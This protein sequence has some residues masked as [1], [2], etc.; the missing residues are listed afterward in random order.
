MP[1]LHISFLVNKRSLAKE[2]KMDNANIGREE[3]EKEIYGPRTRSDIGSSLLLPENPVSLQRATGGDPSNYFAP[4]PD[5]C[6]DEGSPDEMEKEDVD[7]GKDER[8]REIYGDSMRDDV[9]PP[10]HRSGNSVAL[11]HAISEGQFN[12]HATTMDLLPSSPVNE[13]LLNKEEMEDV[14]VGKEEKEK[15]IYGRMMRDDVDSP[16]HR[17]GNLVSLIHASSA[18]QHQTGT[19]FGVDENLLVPLVTARYEN[20]KTVITLHIGAQPNNS[21]HA[22]TMTVFTSAFAFAR[23]LL[24][25][26]QTRFKDMKPS[27]GQSAHDL[28]VN[29]QLDLVDTCPDDNANL[30]EDAYRCQRSHRFTESYITNK[31][32]LDY[33]GLLKTLSGRY[34]VSYIIKYQK[35]LL[36]LPGTPSII[37]NILNNRDRIST[38]ISPQKISLGLRCACPV[39]D[40]GLS[41]KH[42]VRNEYN[43]AQDHTTITFCCPIHGPHTIT[44]EKPDEI[45]RLEMNTPLRNLVRTLA[46]SEISAT[47]TSQETREF[48][49]RVTGADY[50]GFYQEQLSWRQLLLLSQFPQPPIFLYAP[51]IVDWAGSK[52]SKSLY[53]KKG[54]YTYMKDTNTDFLLSY[55]EA[56]EQK[57]DLSVLF[58]EVDNWLV[59][60]NEWIRTRSVE[61]MRM[62]FEDISRERGPFE[63]FHDDQVPDPLGS[64]SYAFEK[65]LACEIPHSIFLP[66]LYNKL[67]TIPRQFAMFI[68]NLSHSFGLQI[69]DSTSRL[70]TTLILHLDAR[71]DSSPTAANT[72]C[73]AVAFCLGQIL[74]QKHNDRSTHRDA[75]QLEAIVE[76]TLTG[77]DSS[78][79]HEYEEIAQK[80]QRFFDEQV[81]FVFKDETDF[82]RGEFLQ[83]CLRRV[84]ED[85]GSISPLLA[86]RNEALGIECTCRSSSPTIL[87]SDTF[88]C[89][90]HEIDLSSADNRSKLKLP[91]NLRNLL[92][93]LVYAKETV[94][95][96]Q[97]KQEVVHMRIVGWEHA[98]IIAEQCLWNPLFKLKDEDI[99]AAPPVTFYAPLIVDWSGAKLSK[100]LYH[101]GAYDYMK[102]SGK[103]YLLSYQ[104]MKGEG[105]D[106]EI[107]FEI[108]KDWVREPKKLFRPY[109]EEYLHRE[110]LKRRQSHEQAGDT[111][112]H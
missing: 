46:Y 60:P 96:R 26:C 77:D 78:H 25:T 98:G 11:D 36:A 75:L 2:K 69:I 3:K 94:S 62:T 43:I 106:V 105:K 97:T 41:D 32:F 9:D 86:P 7:V 88:P 102:I 101:R 52:L 10:F 79:R 29:V 72:T 74:K 85:L 68:R 18:V 66:F 47:S 107:L 1:D 64:G 54:A 12:H 21:P 53:V 8:E 42:G 104:V 82:L 16:L 108:V 95:S 31:D 59:D 109:S 34:G 110:F 27:T 13:R 30:G 63:L 20:R 50:C 81:T 56:R 48:H 37:R 49:L 58:G 76:I 93:S 90:Q 40:C 80:L 100:S 67:H 38:E 91:V 15:E 5:L 70:P 35:D 19:N 33:Q 55:K 4:T 92:R 65:E 24:D 45:I 73:M 111:T 39:K 112:G 17:S 51:L 71:A 83:V 84:M 87:N 23:R 44:L 99:V 57:K 22:G 6:I 103:E 28:S 89:P 14:N 61:Y